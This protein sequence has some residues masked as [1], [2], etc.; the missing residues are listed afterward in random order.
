[1]RNRGEM[2]CRLAIALLLCLGVSG[3][4]RSADAQGVRVLVPYWSEAREQPW[5][6]SDFHRRAEA[7]LNHVGG[8]ALPW[9]L[10][11]G[12]PPAALAD[13]AQAILT[14]LPSRLPLPEGG[15][16][17][18]EW[19]LRRVRGGQRLV[20]WEGVGV[21]FDGTGRL[22]ELEAALA[23]ELGA[24]VR[25]RGPR[26]LP[27]RRVVRDSTMLFYERRSEEPF[28]LRS[29]YAL[30]AR[31]E[32][33]GALPESWVDLVF[34]DEI[35]TTAFAGARGGMV[36]RGWLAT[37]YGTPGGSA[38]DRQ[39]QWRVDPFRYLHLALGLAGRL[40]WDVSA[41]N[42][43]R[44][45]YSQIDGDNL[46]GLSKIDKRRTNGEVILDSLL[47]PLGYPVTASFIVKELHPKY[48]KRREPLEFMRRLAVKPF[49]EVAT[50]TFSHPYVYNE[51][52]RR[53][54]FNAYG[55]ENALGDEFHLPMGETFRLDMRREIAGSALSLDTLLKG[56][57]KSCRLL[58][59][60]GNCQPDSAALS[61]ATAG[62]LL[63]LNGG[64]G[65]WDR[66]YPSVSNLAPLGVA[67]G[68]GFQVY[69]SMANETIFTN[70]W[71]GPFYGFRKVVET[72][73]NT[74]AGRLLRPV[75][76]Y[77]H[78]YS[79]ERSASLEALREVWRWAMAQELNPVFAS[80]YAQR[81]QN[82]R[83][84][85]LVAEGGRGWAMTPRVRNATLRLD[86][87]PVG[88]RLDPLLEPDLA[89]C[90]N[91]I[92]WKRMSGALYIH[93]L[94]AVPSRVVLREVAS[95]SVET[96]AT[97]GAAPGVTPGGGVR[98]LDCNGEL[99]EWSR[100]GEVLK[101][102]LSSWEKPLLRIAGLPA[103]ARV[104]VQVQAG[105]RSE[106]LPLQVGKD[107][108]LEWRGSAIHRGQA[109]EW[110]ARW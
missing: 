72:L 94:E 52:Q 74:G 14:W 88:S 58:Q 103:G 70:L 3:G 98:L 21:D 33:A 66:A 71:Q 65:R 28:P 46:L 77:Y 60:S 32:S 1:L 19:L 35:N 102:K 8:E 92:G 11:D 23:Q 107:G 62:R 43:T 109:L 2:A 13:S 5:R 10:R 24:R 104:R 42:G 110:E 26:N 68:R 76:I 51:A 25:H 82:W 63:N 27:K 36:A 80:E 86:D 59:W 53:R 6:E 101:V 96:A 47:I 64:D 54:D 83:E 106:L 90:R 20:V 55:G 67:V 45:V 48:Q 15:R 99:Q 30:I 41:K 79:G 38:T 91:V 105:G 17:W 37:W 29:T 44:M 34:A 69:S 93:L 39:M 108:T 78:W 12:L 9:N 16:P 50:H 22:G 18:L 100:Q 56:T 73:A 57:G 7:V 31:P 40:Q 89:Q 49:T 61:Y 75:N 84:A 97:P 87:A 81:V 85:S 95:R 4:A